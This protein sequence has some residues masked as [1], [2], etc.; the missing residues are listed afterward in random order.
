M[1]EQELDPNGVEDG[2]LQG[3]YPAVKDQRSLE[4]A[5]ALSRAVNDWQVE[6]W[7][8]PEPRLKASIS[9]CCDDAEVAVAEIERRA[10]DRH[11]AQVF[12]TARTAEPPGRTRYRPIFEAASRHGNPVGIHPGGANGVPDAPRARESVGTG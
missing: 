11:F 4:F 12:L 5:A 7:A 2:I 6:E 9:L 1:R 8:K 3:L 10:G